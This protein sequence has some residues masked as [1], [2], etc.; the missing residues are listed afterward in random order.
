MD[1][2]KTVERRKPTIKGITEKIIALQRSELIKK[3]G[4]KELVA[5]SKKGK[6][7]AQ[8][9]LR[10]RFGKRLEKAIHQEAARRKILRF[11]RKNAEAEAFKNLVN[12]IQKSTSKPSALS[13]N[14]KTMIDYSAKDALKASFPYLYLDKRKMKK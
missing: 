10:R 12:R 6:S 13:G 11:S 1:M 5:L 3:A 7:P 8:R 14:M 9:E 2:K 4:V